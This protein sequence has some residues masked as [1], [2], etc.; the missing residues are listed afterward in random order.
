MQR[1]V[2]SGKP[3]TIAIAV[4]STKSNRTHSLRRSIRAQVAGKCGHEK[5][6]EKV[7]SNVSRFLTVFDVELGQM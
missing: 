7:I 1:E 3:N 2:M 5:Q 4:V 6:C